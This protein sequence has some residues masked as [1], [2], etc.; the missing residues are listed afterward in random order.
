MNGRWWRLANHVFTAAFVV[1]LTVGLVLFVRAQDWTPVATLAGQL[2]PLRVTAALGAAL[3]INAVGLLLGLASWRALFVDLGAAVDKWTAYRLF[4]VGFLAK[5][6]P[7]RFVALPVLLRM[8]KEIEVGPVRLAGVF[9]LSWAVV[10]MTG[11]TVALAAGPAL[12]SGATGWLLVA[13]VPLVVL[14]ARPDLLN[15]G[16]AAAARLLRRPPPQVTA[17]PTGIRRAV[18]AQSLSW[19][20]SGHHLWLLAVVA[21][22]PPGRSYLICVAGFAA[23]TVAGLSVMIAPDGLGVREAVL[24]LGLVTVLPVAVATPVVLVS[25]L[26]CALSE[27][28][29]GGGGL[30]LAQYMHRR[31]RD[32]VQRV[33]PVG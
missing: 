32:P 20:V 10:A 9:L 7:G 16:L 23:A 6:V 25:R 8:G 11:M 1:A 13:T 21:G 5:F 31:R 15:R 28:A 22:A 33:A 14:V 26:V 30:L 4:F 24:M 27:V 17:S 12:L 3:L 2:D 29:V 19:L 18:T